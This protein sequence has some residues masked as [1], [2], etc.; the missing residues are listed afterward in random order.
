MKVNFGCI[1]ILTRVQSKS[2]YSLTL[3]W[4]DGRCHEVIFLMW[5]RSSFTWDE[6]VSESHDWVSSLAMCSHWPALCRLGQQGEQGWAYRC[7]GF[8]G[9]IL[10]AELSHNLLSLKSSLKAAYAYELLQERRWK[11]RV[12]ERTIYARCLPLHIHLLFKW[13]W[14][15]VSRFPGI[16]PGRLRMK[17]G[18]LCRWDVLGALLW[19][20]AAGQILCLYLQDLCYLG[21]ANQ[22]EI[23]QTE[24]VEIFLSVLKREGS[25]PTV[26]TSCSEL[27][28][29]E[30]ARQ[31]GFGS[32]GLK[33]LCS[34]SLDILSL[35][36]G[37]SLAKI[38]R[39]Q[40]HIVLN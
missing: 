1:N 5:S 8:M 34:H 13:D 38:K 39:S 9:T 2:L 15:A 26:Q 24:S 21:G 19:I 28:L 30:P 10:L 36:L 17:L 4:C 16:G 25:S 27:W 23:L 6:Q 37:I 7:S 14:F 22:L 31:A 3:N 18:A 29:P 33:H 32:K 40:A 20:Q 12:K 11:E 35:L